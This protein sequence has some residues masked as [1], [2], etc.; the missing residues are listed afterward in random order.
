MNRK[1]FIFVLIAVC[2]LLGIGN[3]YAEEGENKIGSSMQVCVYCDHNDKSKCRY[4]AQ[5][6]YVA[7]DNKYSYDVYYMASNKFNRWYPR[8]EQLFDIDSDKIVFDTASP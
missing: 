7:Q 4:L 8:Y 3:V 2:F 6:N 5:D 1:P